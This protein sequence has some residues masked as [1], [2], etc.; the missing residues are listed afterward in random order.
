MLNPEKMLDD[1]CIK[2]GEH[3]EEAGEEFPQLLVK[4]LTNMLW[5]EKLEN[6]FLR[7]CLNKTTAN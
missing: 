2:Y 7:R 5:K 6:E 3:L 4:I 1:I